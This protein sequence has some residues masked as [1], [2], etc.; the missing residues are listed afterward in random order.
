MASSVDR[1]NRYKPAVDRSEK[2]AFNA[3][4]TS[5]ELPFEAHHGV[6]SKAEATPEPGKYD[7]R[8]TEKGKGLTADAETLGTFNKSAKEGKAQFNVTSPAQTSDTTTKQ[9]AASWQ[10]PGLLTDPGAYNPNVNREIDHQSKKTFQTRGKKG[11]AA[12]GG[13]HART[14]KLS[15]QATHTPKAGFDSNGVE[16]TPGAGAYSPVITETGREHDMWNLNGT[17]KM[18]SASFATK[19]QRPGNALPN[20]KNPGPGEYKPRYKAVEPEKGN[21]MSKVSRSARYTADNLDGGGEDCTTGAFVGPGSYSPQQLFGGDS[22][23]ISRKNDIAVA[24]GFGTNASFTSGSIRTRFQ[25]GD[26][27]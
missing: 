9:V 14:T 6:A 2:L 11:D 22:D 25:V 12:F 20:Y 27:S 7:P 16:E 8:V 15:N 3:S 5:R 21:K 13:T 17:E 26:Y 18:K 1:S 4:G 19:T 23:S 10:N 24:T